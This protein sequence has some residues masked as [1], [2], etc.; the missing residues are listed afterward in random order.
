MVFVTKILIP[1][2]AAV[3][4]QL[5]D[6]RLWIL[7]FQ[8]G[9]YPSLSSIEHPVTSIDPTMESVIFSPMSSY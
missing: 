3:M 2:F 9:R 6:A 8:N 7:D 4:D 1:I 5:L